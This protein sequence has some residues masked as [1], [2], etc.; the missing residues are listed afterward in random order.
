MDPIAASVPASVASHHLVG[1]SPGPACRV[2]GGF[3]LPA[4][5]T[6]HWSGDGSG[7]DTYVYIY[8]YIPY[9]Y[10]YG[11]YIPHGHGSISHMLHDLH[12][13]YLHIATKLAEFLGRC[14]EIFQ[15]SDSFFT[16]Y[17]IWVGRE[18]SRKTSCT[19]WQTNRGLAGESAHK[20]KTYIYIYI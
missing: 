17:G 3:Q 12:V 1:E 14:W 16:V 13:E 7:D 20:S 6:Q 15:G 11:S 2:P 5:L 4:A 10:G 8:I 19:L 9:V 18:E